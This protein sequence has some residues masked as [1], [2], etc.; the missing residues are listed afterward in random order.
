M[1]TGGHLYG[2]AMF[3]RILLSLALVTSLVVVP[4]HTS[5]AEECAG[6]RCITVTADDESDEIVVSF[7]REGER[8]TV[9]PERGL[10]E[11]SGSFSAISDPMR[12]WIPYHPDLYAAWREAARKAAATRA[13]NQSAPTRSRPSRVVTAALTDRVRQLIPFGSLQT[14]PAAAVVL[15]LPVH[16]WTPTPTSFDV[17]LRVAG[18]PVRLQLTPSFEWGY[19]EGV[20]EIKRTT[21]MPGAPYPAPVNT[22]T[23]SNPG[24]K[25]I[26]LTTTWSG[27]FTIAGV[28]SPIK[29]KIT[30]VSRKVLDVRSAPHHLLD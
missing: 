12:T 29:G 27:D 3:S 30:Q 15:G 6:D 11:V 16:F 7:R 25:N 10:P 5:Q 14:Q 24:L 9:E 20:P 22:F 8:R 18:I 23:Y 17:T 28:R 2:D 21:E 26:S 19:G 4:T 13:R 1:L